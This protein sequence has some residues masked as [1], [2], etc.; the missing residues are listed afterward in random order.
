MFYVSGGD[1]NARVKNAG[2]STT[3]NI[4]TYDAV[5]HKWWRIREFIG[6]FIFDTSPD[7]VLW[8]TR[9][10]IAYTFAITAIT[11]QVRSGYY[12]TEAAGLYSYVDHVNT[13]TEIVPT[14]PPVTVE[15]AFDGG[16]YSSSYSWTDITS[17]VKGFGSKR[18]RS[19]EVDRI[20]AGT[21]DL[22]LDN[23]DGRFTPM[24]DWSTEL[25]S[26]NVATGTDTLGTTSGFLVNTAQPGITMASG[27]STPHSGTKALQYLG[28]SATAATLVYN[29]QT[30]VKPGNKYVASAWVR[31]TVTAGY[32]TMPQR[33]VLRWRDSAGVFISDSNGA[34]WDGVSTSWVQVSATGV[35]PPNAAY[36]ILII[37]ATAVVSSSWVYWTDDW[38]LAEV[39]PYY[40]N[41]I[42][43]RR[44]RVRTA[45]LLPKDTAT[46]GDVS[47]SSV[48]FQTSHVSG[49]SSGYTSGI[50]KQGNGSTRVD[51]VKTG[52][53]TTY[54]NSSIRC[55]FFE[56][57]TWGGWGKWNL[58]A[59]T[60]LEARGLARVVA[61]KTYTASGWYRM[62]AASYADTVTARIRW[63]KDDGTFYNSSSSTVITTVIGSWVYW[64]VTGVAG[65]SS[66]SGV[67]LA[68]VEIGTPGLSAS[69]YGYVDNLQIE[70]A[71]S[72]TTW[73]PG[74]SIFSGFVE[75]WP[76]KLSGL[77]SEVS[78]SAVDAF[79]ILG[80]T[81]LQRPMRQHIMST[82]PWGYWPLT[83]GAGATSAQN[84]ADDTKPAPLKASK[85]GGGTAAFGAASIVANDDG[86]SFSVVNVS[87]T[88]GTV[89]D[90]TN[91]GLAVPTI[92]TEFAASFWCLPTRPSSG[93][94][95]NLFRT[96]GVD[97]LKAAELVLDSDGYITIN[98]GFPDN[99]ANAGGGWHQSVSEIQLSSS[100]PSLVTISITAG[101][102]TL[103]INDQWATSTADTYGAAVAPRLRAPNYITLG[104]NLSPAGPFDFT[105]GRFG[106]L[107]IW[108]RALTTEH[109]MTYYIGA[110]NYG[111]SKSAFY[112]SEGSRLSRLVRY[113]GFTGETVLDAS[114]SGI[115]GF[116]WETGD[117]AL[118]QVQSTAE[119]AS[120][121]A[122]MDGDG[123]LVYHSR[124]RR[125]S[126][127]LRFTLGESANLPYESDLDFQV[128][129]DRIV[130]E[131]A[132][133]RSGGA[134][135]L[136]RDQDSIAT[137][138]RKTKSID[139]SV[140]TDGEVTNAAYWNLNQY[141]APVM[142]CDEVTLSA[143]A[144]P[145]L[146]PVVLG[147]EIGD[148]IRLGDLPA[149]APSSSLDFY[150][151]AIN[152]T[153][154]ADGVTPE[155][156]TVL[157]LSPAVVSDVWVLEDAS[158]GLLDQTA[159]LA[160]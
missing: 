96:T 63:Y 109:E 136:V 10:T 128:D 24:K 94:V 107:A 76:V 132:F 126:A 62:G 135:G 5:A 66:S 28:T 29:A 116:D 36:A 117:S 15:V 48:N 122:F 93:T 130:N 129:E 81:E 38:S 120:G 106:H 111:S 108:D 123:R 44:V 125:Q 41:V 46:G 92:A 149:A 155:W 110:G 68:G 95:S 121:Y 104:G 159:D 113:A 51:F 53:G 99:T 7:G 86:T 52:D 156:V 17:W 85:Y 23:S 34:T 78:V 137:H 75:K 154:T 79:N 84:L 13:P 67:S 31:N 70:E 22:T 47:Q 6:S 102:G 151:E 146:F 152:T 134:S 127:P 100:T 11:F 98:V 21:L 141:K 42:P 20:E 142:R 39:A 61:G 115:L 150:V 143:S 37:A 60:R 69:V 56:T 118:E 16:P 89:V 54:Y 1:F 9:A 59:Q 2:V 58:F 77:T 32:A 91:G 138:G 64:T 139:L 4:G 80:T 40:P 83:E 33:V 157:S 124:K 25:L 147:V 12:G 65:G 8:T 14:I 90:C 119:D 43:R 114:V 45:N 133:T 158:F 49:Q 87:N 145:V 3:V 160:F 148:R 26:G 50:Y 88:K 101:E 27:T 131:V 57:I 71:S 55:G 18:G 73:T 112:E 153:V 105:S 82:A 72:A 103:Y 74:G 35:A 144:C 19:Y 97:G 140:S 30:A